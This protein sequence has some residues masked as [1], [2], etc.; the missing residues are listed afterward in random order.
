MPVEKESKTSQWISALREWLPTV[1]PRLK[2]W[3][4]VVRENPRL[5]WETTNVR[6]AALAVAVL[7]SLFMVRGCVTAII[8]A[9][10]GEPAETALFHVTCTNPGC[11]HHFVIEREFG[12]DDFPVQCPKCGKETGVH[13]VLKPGAGGGRWVP[14]ERR[15]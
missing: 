14:R 11:H 13:A 2:E 3:W 6:W 9:S 8:P 7:V 4:E 12:F 5:I 1:G 10:R 15:D